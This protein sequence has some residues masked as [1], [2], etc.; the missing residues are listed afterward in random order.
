MRIESNAPANILD[1]GEPP[2]LVL[3]ALPLG[4]LVNP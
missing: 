4:G 1:P 3:Q 2:K